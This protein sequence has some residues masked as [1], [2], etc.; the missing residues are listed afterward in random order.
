[1]APTDPDID[2]GQTRELLELLGTEVVWLVLRELLS[3]EHMRQ[4]ELATE[5]GVERTQVGRAL[6]SLRSARLVASD[7]GRN[8]E[9]RAVLRDEVLGL[10]RAGDQL[11]DAVNERRR[12]GQRRA[13]RRTQK[14]GLKPVRENERESL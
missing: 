2:E 14:D 3:H 8:A 9:H 10:I 13:G 11:A 1:V 6:A 4:D 7:R 12:E 5:T